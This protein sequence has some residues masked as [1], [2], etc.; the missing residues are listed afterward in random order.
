MKVL[1]ID[2]HKSS[3]PTP[4]NNLHWINAKIIADRF[5]G[6]LIWSYPTVNDNIK[7]GYDIIIFVHAS[8]YSF[9]DYAWLEASPNAKIFHVTNEYNL[10]EP[11]IL[12]MAVKAGRRYNVIANHEAK[13]SKLVGKYIDD[14]NI[15][16][17]NALCINP[18]LIEINKSNNIEGDFEEDKALYYGS[19]RKGRIKY[20]EKYF[21]SPSMIVSSHKKNHEKFHKID[22]KP[23]F[24]TRIN[25]S[26]DGL[27]KYLYS[28]YIEDEKTHT[29]YNF[30]ANRFYEALNYQV[31][32]LFDA[33]CANTLNRCGYN[34]GPEYIINSPEELA[35]KIQDPPEF[36][37]TWI[38]QA[39]DEKESVLNK[40]D[41]IIR[42]KHV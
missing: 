3:K 8:M 40:I 37:L 15:V 21:N 34:I 31:I 10:G 7:S 19:F 18:E 11:R 30:L 33:S 1:V 25:W 4:A 32:P 20:F 26:K 29:Y 16:N 2:S 39:I 22:V 35:A 41:N 13:P 24:I 27:S 14:W 9:V 38:D 23:E 12:W 6:D 17:L 28:L 5:G 42:S 36:K